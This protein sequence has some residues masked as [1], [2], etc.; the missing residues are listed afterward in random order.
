MST[1]TMIHT[2]PIP[3]AQGRKWSRCGCLT[4]RSRYEDACRRY[5]RVARVANVV[6]LD[7]GTEC[8]LMRQ[9]QLPLV[10]GRPR[11][12]PGPEGPGH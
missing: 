11:C 8:V 9:P 3:P 2:T 4:Q 12:P 10:P 7:P 1:Q 6:A 5:S